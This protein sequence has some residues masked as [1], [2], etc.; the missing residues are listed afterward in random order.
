MKSQHHN[1]R[2]ILSGK[3]SAMTPSMI[4]L[5]VILV[6]I[7][8]SIFSFF[9]IRNT[10]SFLPST[11]DLMTDWHK[12]NYQS[13]YDQSQVLLQ[14][15]P[16]DGL[17]LS[18]NGFASYYL[19]TAQTDPAV[20]RAYLSNCI[21]S[22]RNAW[23]RVAQSDR[24]Y[25]A[26]I[27]GKAYYHQGFYYADLAMKYLDFA[28][29]GGLR[30]ADLQEFRGLSASLLDDL[31]SA[32]AAFTEALGNNP[33][34]MILFT[35]AQHHAKAGNIQE[36]KQYLFETIRT[37]SDELLELK[38][39]YE[40]GSLLL[41]EG[42][43]ASAQKEFETILEKDANYTDAHYGL[44][45][46]YELQGDLVRARASWRRAVRLNPVHADARKKLNLS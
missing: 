45:V 13:V 39:R 42:D 10:G 24:V 1:R 37:T 9:L 38:G 3:H 35:L 34:D 36:S 16:L 14:Q 46:I 28:Y 11:R 25:I 41:L 23:Y 5:L 22:L 15:R 6:L 17:A 33:S 12:Q 30:Q 43:L 31:D 21:I 19:F 20:G 18:F 27:L 7:V 8:G 44:G 32:I 40:L 2:Y 29:D 26:Y 4:A